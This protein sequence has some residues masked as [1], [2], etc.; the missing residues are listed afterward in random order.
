MDEPVTEA[1][2]C[3]RSCHPNDTQMFKDYTRSDV[4]KVYAASA[5]TLTTAARFHCEEDE[6]IEEASDDA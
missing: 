2:K 3:S 5:R 6:D 4:F 1:L